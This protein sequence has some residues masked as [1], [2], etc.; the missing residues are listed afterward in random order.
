MVLL[1]VFL[2]LQ[3]S[4]LIHRKTIYFFILT[5]Y[6]ATLVVKLIVVVCF[7]CLFFFRIQQ[8][9]IY[10][11]RQ[12][13]F[14]QGTSFFLPCFYKYLYKLR[15]LSF[16]FRYQEFFYKAYLYPINMYNYT[17]IK[18]KKTFYFNYCCIGDIVIFIKFLTVYHS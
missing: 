18:N 4:L 17:S 3:F 13:Y 6:T 10:K 7:C 9:V 14:F 5:K 1:M 16:I 8:I 15:I 12:L 2:K 11:Q